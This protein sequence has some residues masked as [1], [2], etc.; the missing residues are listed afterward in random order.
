LYS[1]WFDQ[2]NSGHCSGFGRFQAC[3][4]H[5]RGRCDPLSTGKNFHTLALSLLHTPAI[6][7]LPL[8]LSLALTGPA[9]AQQI[10]DSYTTTWDRT[11]LFTYENQAPNPVNF[12]TPGPDGAAVIDIQDSTLYQ[13]LDGFGASLTDRSAYLLWNMKVRA[14][15][16]EMIV[17]SR[18]TLGFLD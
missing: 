1:A 16:S 5:V 11:K 8:P 10:W 6:M 12:D 2:T 4:N 17:F 15:L 7:R 18:L 13:Q 14:Y 9:F 3:K